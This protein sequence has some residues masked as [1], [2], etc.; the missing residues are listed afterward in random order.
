MELALLAGKWVFIGLIYLFVF[1]VYRGLIREGMVQEGERAPVREGPR[2]YRRETAPGPTSAQEPRPGSVAVAPPRPRP[3]PP[4]AQMPL[5][6]PS[7]GETSGSLAA[8][9]SPAL[10]EALQEEP[11]P[12]SAAVPAAPLQSGR[13]PRQTEARTD[14]A[15]LVV[16]HSQTPEIPVGHE[17]PLL[18]AAT[19]GRAD[20]NAI[21]LPDQFA[22]MQHAVIFL[23][24]GRRVLRDR[25]STNGTLLNGR[26]VDTDMVLRDEDE[27]TI[28]TTVL[29]Y[30]QPSPGGR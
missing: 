19:I 23:Q 5:P 30:S 3:Q 13:V 15:K 4:V 18:A 9:M 11:T 8:G 1:V 22:S 6:T 17:Y 26:K 29:R 21:V 2:V 25:G 10:R 24:D 20:Y 12:S 16:I 28:G 14:T 7:S 27:I